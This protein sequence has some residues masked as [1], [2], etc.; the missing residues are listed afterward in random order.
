MG[1]DLCFRRLFVRRVVQPSGQHV[2]MHGFG[3]L[4]LFALR[5]RSTQ[6][7][8]HQ[9]RILGSPLDGL[10]HH[11]H[12]HLVK[13]LTDGLRACGCR[14]QRTGAAT[15][16]R[17]TDFGTDHAHRKFADRICALNDVLKRYFVIHRIFDAK[18]LVC[19]TTDVSQF[20]WRHDALSAHD[21]GK[22]GLILGKG[23]KE[24][25]PELLRVENVR[26]ARG[27]GEDIVIQR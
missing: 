3:E 8:R 7:L 12:R 2:R 15:R 13:D 6:Q 17:R 19:E 26:A 10:A 21:V 18:H 9:R 24:R 20:L 11:H 5:G 16:G 1:R 14:D 4:E 25:V 27:F 23:L 22:C